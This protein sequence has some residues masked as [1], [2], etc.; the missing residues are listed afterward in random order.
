MPDLKTGRR[1]VGTCN[2]CKTAIYSDQDWGETHTPYTGS[3]FTSLVTVRK[4][5][6]FHHAM[7]Y[8]RRNVTH[9]E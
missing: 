3:V 4:Y 1:I 2:W 8:I 9:Q 7:R 6:C 5:D